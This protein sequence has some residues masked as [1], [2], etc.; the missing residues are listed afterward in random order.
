MDLTPNLNT[1]T[2]WWTL[3]GI[4]AIA[5]L[6]AFYVVDGIVWLFR[7]IKQA[8]ADRIRAWR[9]EHPKSWQPRP[10]PWRAPVPFYRFWDPRSG[11]LGGALF[12]LLLLAAYA[13]AY[14]LMGAQ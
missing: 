7:K 2:T 12:G 10:L 9:L 3:A 4:V 14:R 8:I 6:I 13:I 5:A 1:F 11:L